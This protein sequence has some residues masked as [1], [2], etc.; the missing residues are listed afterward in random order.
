M[1]TSTSPNRRELGMSDLSTI[2]RAELERRF[3]LLQRLAPLATAIDVARAK[4]PG[5]PDG[6]R[7]LAE[8]LGEV[9]SAIRRES[10]ERV[11]EELLDLATV[12]MRLYLREGSIGQ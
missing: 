10:P 1:S 9:A 11:R 2:G 3:I 7:S 4:H 12:A 6:M 5:G 8:E